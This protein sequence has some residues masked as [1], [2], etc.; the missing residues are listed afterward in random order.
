MTSFSRKWN[1]L[2]GRAAALLLCLSVMSLPAFAAGD[3]EGRTPLV[4]P[5]AEN[6]A[7]SVRL[8]P[9]FTFGNTTDP[10]MEY[11]IY[12]VADGALIQTIPVSQP[13]E[14]LEVVSYQELLDD[15]QHFVT[16]ED[17]DGDGKDDLKV[18]TGNGG[19]QGEPVY[20]TY[21][22][23]KSASAFVEGVAPTWAVR[24]RLPL[25]GAGALVLLG[26]A[27]LILKKKKA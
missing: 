18:L 7:V 25:I 6:E 20:T 24:Y 19:G 10:Y 14:V 5:L 23:D 26:A 15:P 3:P 16:L 22:W 1:R 4:P 9:N 21:L 11:E 12:A 13:R 8:A 2:V 17:L 27:A